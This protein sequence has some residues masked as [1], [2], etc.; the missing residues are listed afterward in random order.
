MMTRRVKDTRFPVSIFLVSLLT[1]FLVSGIHMGLITMLGLFELNSWV[2]SIILISFWVSIS[3][4]FTLFTTYQIR[5]TYEKPLMDMASATRKV[6]E[7]DFSVYV[8][9]YHNMDNLDYLDVMI[10]DFNKMVE[11]L[12]SIET[13]KTDFF[14]NVS[15]EIKTPLAVISNSAQLMKKRADLTE[16][17]IEDVKLILGASKRL[18]SLI[19]NILKLNRLE[20]Q[21]IL[22]EVEPFDV[23]A[24]ICN[25]LIQFEDRW[26]RKEIELDVDFE[27]Q[28][29]INADMGL[30]ELVWN[31]LIG[32]AIKFTEIGGSIHIKEESDDE[33]IRISIADSGC[34]MSEET[35]KHIFEKFYQGDTSHAMEGNGLGLALA[36]RILQMSEGTIAVESEIGRGTTF[37]VQL[38]KKEMRG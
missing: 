8:A 30:M 20:K 18:T 7:G 4:L 38:P 17:Q 37:T 33:C 24:Q 23:C 5:K 36:N 29:Y 11:D 2:Q 35:I 9:P 32:N 34:G 31:N 15:H 3:L 16:E 6:A 19:T 26:E 27:D 21:V 14:S 25:C 22:P 13:L 1:M 28:A 10:L 12:G